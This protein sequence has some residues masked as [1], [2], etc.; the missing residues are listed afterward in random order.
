MTNWASKHQ[1]LILRGL[2][3]T[4][5]LISWSLIIFPLWGAFLAPTLVAYYIIAFDIYWLYRSVWTAIFSLLGH[6]RLKA[7]QQLDW[8]NEAR[9]FL[10][11]KKVK[12]I[13]VIPTYKEPLHTLERTLTALKQQSFHR[14]N[15]TVVLAFETREGQQAHDKA[16]ALTQKFAQS[17]GNFLVTFHP[18]I[19]GEVKGKYSN[20]SWICL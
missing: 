4:P 15:L 20:T 18:D 5:G 1:K 17:F 2:E 8:L 10:D 14:A 13:I 9:S 11:W 6:F 3:I 12:H 19:R 7:S 16:A